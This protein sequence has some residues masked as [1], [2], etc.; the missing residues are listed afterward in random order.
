[1]ITKLWDN[2]DG[3]LKLHW[4]YLHIST[5]CKQQN[6]CS[7]PYSQISNY[8]DKDT[9]DTHKQHQISDIRLL[10][11]YTIR[12][13]TTPTLSTFDFSSSHSVNQYVFF[14]ITKAITA[15]AQKHK[16]R[17]SHPIAHDTTKET[18]TGTLLPSTSTAIRLLGL[19]FS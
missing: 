11:Q 4:I 3:Y 5:K 12:L 10:Q 8:D 15:M 2:D 13:I 1:M 14:M 18:K 9:N 16:L 17:V 6:I 7:D 19:A